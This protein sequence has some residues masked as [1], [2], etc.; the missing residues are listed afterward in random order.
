MWIEDVRRGVGD[1]GCTGLGGLVADEVG[2]GRRSDIAL[3]ALDNIVE[4]SRNE[5]PPVPADSMSIAELSAA[6]G[7]RSSTLRFWEQQGLITPERSEPSN[8]RRYPPRAVHDARIVTALRAGG[9]RIPAVRATM[10]TLQTVDDPQHARS[11]LQ[12]RLDTIATQSEAL[13]LAGTDLVRLLGVRT[14]RHTEA[15]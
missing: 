15:I 1:V 2:D 8:A 10:A 14:G 7:V 13:L 6:L 5:A 12:A 3:S 9:Y 11:A 4:E